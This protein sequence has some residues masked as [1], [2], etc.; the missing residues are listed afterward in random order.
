[1]LGVVLVEVDHHLLV[2][3]HPLAV[4]EVLHL[5]GVGQHQRLLQFQEALLLEE[6]VR[7]GALQLLFVQVNPKL[8]QVLRHR[9]PK[10]FMKPP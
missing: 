4:Q 1:M 5:V 6:I 7:V 3:L 8:D 2:D 10:S 9:L